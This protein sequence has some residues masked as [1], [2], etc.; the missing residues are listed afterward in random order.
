MLREHGIASTEVSAM[1]TEFSLSISIDRTNLCPNIVARPITSTKVTPTEARVWPFDVRT[2]NGDNLDIAGIADFLQINGKGQESV[3]KLLTELLDIFLKKEA[4]V[5]ETSIALEEDGQM[6]I[7]RAR[8]GFDDAA[9]KSAG[10]QKDVHSLRDKSQ[11]IPE[12]VEAEK[13]GI[14]YVTYV[15]P[16]LA[17]FI[18]YI[19]SLDSAVQA[20]LAL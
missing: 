5:L 11:E 13:D 12:E 8:F 4:F 1:A 15:N 10:R 14:I 2:V 3:K 19:I 9:L 18:A 20:Q 6:Q 17:L 7:M 16:P